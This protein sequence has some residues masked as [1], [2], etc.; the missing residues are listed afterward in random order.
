MADNP[1][2]VK[3]REEIIDAFDLTE[4]YGPRE[5]DCLFAAFAAWNT[6]ATPDQMAGVDGEVTQETLDRVGE[7]IVRAG[8]PS[9]EGP[10]GG[11]DYGY[12]EEFYG[13]APKGGR[14]VVRDYRVVG[15]PTWGAWVH[16]T[17][18]RD[19][20]E[21]AFQRLTRRHIAS[22]ALKAAA[23]RQEPHP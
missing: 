10:Y 6:R 23:I 20:H 5:I 13:S 18:D 17:N 3:A 2:E 16:Q 4:H 15:S 21:A 9:R 8:C 11:Y 19:E 7:A 12:N 22:E 14:Y 1:L